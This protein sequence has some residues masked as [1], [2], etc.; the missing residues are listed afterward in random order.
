MERS[1]TLGDCPLLFLEPVNN[2]FEK[3]DFKAARSTQVDVTAIPRG[4]IIRSV[5]PPG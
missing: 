1:S 5:E 3:T 2:E 4:V